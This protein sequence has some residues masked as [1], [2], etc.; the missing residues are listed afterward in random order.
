MS[1]VISCH[2]THVFCVPVQDSSAAL[3]TS[4]DGLKAAKEADQQEEVGR[5]AEAIVEAQLQ[6]SQAQAALEEVEPLLAGADAKARGHGAKAAPCEALPRIM[7]AVVVSTAALR[8][9]DAGLERVKAFV[10]APRGD[11][12][13][14]GPS[15]QRSPHGEEPSQPR[16]HALFRSFSPF[17]RAEPWTWRAP[18]AERSW[19][20]R[21]WRALS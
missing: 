10:G 8:G 11:H 12:V 1:H 16:E 4:R 21:C 9:A 2:V 20:W 14:W 15:P 3:A 7:G 19:C 18:E 13:T 17:S 6:Q 5:A